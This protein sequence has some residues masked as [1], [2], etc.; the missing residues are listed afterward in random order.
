MATFKVIIVGGGLA[1]TLLANGL[2]NNDVD[3][4]VYERDAQDSKR[5]GYQIR[6]GQSAMIGI[7]ACLSEAQKIPILEKFGQSTGSTSTAPTLYNTRFQPLL[8]LTRLPSYSRSSAIN[9]VILRNLMMEPVLGQDRVYFNKAFSHY[10][11]LPDE[12][13]YER[14]KVNFTDGTSDVA[15]LLIGADGSGSKINK[16]IGAR[17]IVDI[18]THWTFL[19]KGNLPID[20]IKRLPRQLQK[21]PILLLSKSTVLFYALYLPPEKDGQQKA[22]VD[23]I[24]YNQDEA[25]FYWA[26]SVPKQIDKYEDVK[27]IPDRR[28]FVLDYVSDWAPEFRTMLSVGADD[29]DAGEIFATQFRASHKLSKQWRVHARAQGDAT[30]AQGHPRVW[31]MGDAIHAMQPNRGMGANQAMR[32]CAEM[33]PELLGLNRIVKAGSRPTTA[34]VSA[35]CKRFEDGMIDRAFVWVKKSGGASIKAIDLDGVLGTI[36]FILGIIFLP[37]ARFIYLVVLRKGANQDE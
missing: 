11:I 29:E 26:F 34:Q 35:A 19:A 2:L 10:E 1:G 25:S 32:D 12:H 28:K 37:I 18:N 24:Q 23:E 20:R 22:A 15:D 16:Q 27:D 7:N 9:R 33:L 13:G 4:I 30:A 6:L 31:L 3:V 21:G 5:E 8:D 17:N 36:I 14:V